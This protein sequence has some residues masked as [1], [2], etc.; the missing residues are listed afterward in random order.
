LILIHSTS[1]SFVYYNAEPFSRRKY[2]RLPV[3]KVLLAGIC[4]PGIRFLASL[5]GARNVGIY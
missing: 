5:V 1:E 3:K 4:A 2:E